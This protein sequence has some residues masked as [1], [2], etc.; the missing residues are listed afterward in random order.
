MVG[1]FKYDQKDSVNAHLM[2]IYFAFHF[3]K[4][5]IYQI[6]DHVVFGTEIIIKCFTHDIGA[7]Q[8]SVT[9]ISS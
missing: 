4:N 7:L 2:Q 6:I 3:L 9:V 1:K 8:I 5:A